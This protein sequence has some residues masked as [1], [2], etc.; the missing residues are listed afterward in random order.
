[1]A[2]RH[3][4]VTGAGTGIGRAVALR[5]ARDG[6]SVTLL[7][8]RQA[9]ARGDGAPDRRR[10]PR[11]GRA[12]SATA[13]RSTARSIARRRASARSTRSSLSAA[14]GGPNAEDDAGG[15][16]FDDLVRD[17]PQRHVLL[18]A[19]RAPSS[20]AG[21]AAAPRRRHLVDP[22]ADRRPRVHGLQ[23]LEGR[24]AR[25]RALVRRRAR[26][27]ERPGERDLPRL[28]RDGHGLTGPRRCSPS[29]SEARGRRLRVA[30]RAVPLG[31][32]SQPEDIAGTVA[33][34]LSAGRARDHRSGDRPEWRR[35]G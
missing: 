9:R 17:E 15:D 13:R 1:M 34:L 20:G 14:I 2:S 16:R 21:A 29:R 19:R 31:R 30:M 12:T 26:A 7:G 32:M 3:V 25:A 28:G 11:R 5:L 18:R 35:L 8:L 10:R 33:W 24:A 6:A 23:R 27:G 4:V 22:R